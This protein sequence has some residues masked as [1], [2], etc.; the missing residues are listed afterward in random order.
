MESNQADCK[1]EQSSQLVHDEREVKPEKLS[2]NGVEGFCKHKD[3]NGYGEEKKDCALAKKDVSSP[4]VESGLKCDSLKDSETL[5][6]SC[7]QA[8]LAIKDACNVKENHLSENGSTEQVESIVNHLHDEE[9]GISDCLSSKVS[10]D[11]APFSPSVANL[12][13]TVE[14]THQST[15]SSEIEAVGDSYNEIEKGQE[16]SG[17]PPPSE[18]FQEEIPALKESVGNRNP[19]PDSIE[20][21]VKQNMSTPIPAP[22]TPVFEDITDDEDDSDPDTTGDNNIELD[23]NDLIEPSELYTEPTAEDKKLKKSSDDS[24]S[25]LNPDSQDHVHSHGKQNLLKT[26]ISEDMHGTS[27]DTSEN[28]FTLLKSSETVKG[29]AKIFPKLKVTARKSGRPVSQSDSAPLKTINLHPIKDITMDVSEVEDALYLSKSSSSNAELKCQESKESSSTENSVSI[30][31]IKPFLGGR[32]KKRKK[33]YDLPGCRK[34]LKKIRSDAESIGSSAD[35][36]SL[37]DSV[38]LSDGEIQEAD[39]NKDVL[40]LT[41][42]TAGAKLQTSLQGASAKVESAL[43]ILTKNSHLGFAKKSKSHSSSAAVSS[44]SSSNSTT[45]LPSS[46][47]YLFPPSKLGSTAKKS[48]KIKSVLD[49]LHRRS[50]QRAESAS[51][52]A[53]ESVASTSESSS[54]TTVSS[55]NSTSLSS[56]QGAGTITTTICVTSSESSTTTTIVSFITLKSHIKA[57][58]K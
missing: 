4:E 15:N 35:S 51:D 2:I 26:V 40:G 53:V 46:R 58:A 52:S 20:V 57:S 54:T 14:N 24:V 23:L 42:D 33:S 55:S 29:K 38:S 6:S 9:N 44:S 16:K 3:Q 18:G 1:N 32:K 45:F 39:S 31:D 25:D 13:D 37:A 47:K 5:D 41:L 34:R 49:M 28:N 22:V 11:S 21:D 19:L 8:N 7:D 12:P 56:K 50:Q 10:T 27:K 48:G 36:I 17:S 43:D 30:N